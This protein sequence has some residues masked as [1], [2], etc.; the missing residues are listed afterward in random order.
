MLL[1]TKW[2]EILYFVLI[3]FY[4]CGELSVAMYVLLIQNFVS[5][6]F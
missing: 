4:C 5:V 2:F 1:I 6:G 3:S